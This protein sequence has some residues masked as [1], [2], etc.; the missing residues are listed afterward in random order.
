MAPTVTF[1]VEHI[2]ALGTAVSTARSSTEFHER[3]EEYLR[4]RLQDMDNLISERGRTIQ[5]QDAAISMLNENLRTLEQ[6]VLSSN[7]KIED[8]AR[9]RDYYRDEYNALLREAEA[10]RREKQINVQGLSFPEIYN[11]IKDLSWFFIECANHANGG[12]KINAI[13]VYR[14]NTGEGLKESKDFVEWYIATKPELPT[15][16]AAMWAK[17]EASAMEGGSLNRIEGIKAYRRLFGVGLKEA[18]DA[19]EKHFPLDHR[20]E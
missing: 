5:R 3:E 10:R 18:K 19:V 20:G 17:V 8:L 9:D 13:K 16:M 6:Q 2:I 4:G 14:E 12:Q 15:A 11:K 1:D 7:Y